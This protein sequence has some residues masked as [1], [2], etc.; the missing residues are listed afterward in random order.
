MNSYNLENQVNSIAQLNACDK[1]SLCSKLTNFK[2]AGNELVN[3]INSMLS[4]WDDIVYKKKKIIEKLNEDILETKLQ[5]IKKKEI[6]DKKMTNDISAFNILKQDWKTMVDESKKFKVGKIIKV[7]VGG[8]IFVTSSNMFENCWLKRNF[9]TSMFSGNWYADKDMDGQ[10]FIDRDGTH[11]K[12]IL[13]FIRDQ[14]YK[15]VIAELS[16]SIQQELLIEAD[17]YRINEL[18]ELL[19][20]GL[21]TGI[22]LINKRVK[23]FWKTDKKWYSGLISNYRIYND[24]HLVTYDDSDEKWHNLTKMKWE[25]V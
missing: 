2:T 15:S 13:N 16:K 25:L 1:V 24:Q 5:V 4:Y 10:Y 21:N 7:S 20:T 3:N 12:Y 8:T 9:L 22:G 17:Y 6:F 11:F 23:V 14:Q 18:V 19:Q